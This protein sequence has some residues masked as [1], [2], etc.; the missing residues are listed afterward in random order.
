MSSPRDRG[1]LDGHCCLY[2]ETPDENRCLGKVG[3][4]DRHFII[5]A[6]PHPVALTYCHECA[7]QMLPKQKLNGWFRAELSAEELLVFNIMD[8]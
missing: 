6:G 4:P 1:A 2:R 8:R 5:Q 7:E 3:S